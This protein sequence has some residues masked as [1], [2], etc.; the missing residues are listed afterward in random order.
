MSH[1]FIVL[2]ALTWVQFYIFVVELYHIA[3]LECFCMLGF[4]VALAQIHILALVL[5]SI[6]APVQLYIVAV[7]P[8]YNPVLEYSRIVALALFWVPV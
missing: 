6:V 8:K 4:L 5:E 7:G 3:L 1:N 2:I